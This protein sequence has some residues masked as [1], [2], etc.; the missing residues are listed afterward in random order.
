M[1]AHPLGEA[2][3]RIHYDYD[4]QFGELRM[5]A[6]E[7]N[8]KLAF[9]GKRGQAAL[10][11]LEAALLALPEPKLAADQFCVVRPH[12]GVPGQPIV[13]ACAL[14]ALAWHKG[15]AERVPEDFNPVLVY[16]PV[17]YTHLTLPTNREV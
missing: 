5:G 13:E 8:T 9:E 11:D 4:E 1:E 2:M 10:R 16:N 15:I 6:W 7:H 17:S 3:S 14:G 12:L